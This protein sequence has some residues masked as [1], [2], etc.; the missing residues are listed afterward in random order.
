MPVVRIDLPRFSMMVGEKRKTIVARLPYVG[1][2]IESV[3]SGSVRVEYSPNRPDL[4]T[5]FGIAR[6]LRGLLGREIGLPRFSTRPAAKKS[7]LPG[8][9][10]RD[11]RPP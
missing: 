11:S 10:P 3:S 7:R 1:L 9:R 4:G 2:D 8:S 5:D 6:A